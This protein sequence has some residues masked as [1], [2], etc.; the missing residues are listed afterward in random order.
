MFIREALI[1][2]KKDLGRTLD[3]LET[4]KDIGAIGYLGISTGAEFAPVLLAGEERVKAA[5]LLSGAMPV[6]MKLM[7]ESNPVN[8]TP[9]MKTPVLMLNGRYDS[10]LLPDA[11]EWMFRS[12][13]TAMP[14]KAH[15]LVNSGHSVLAPEVRNQ[16]I[17]QILDWF[18]RHL[19]SR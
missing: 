2:W 6:Q 18:D 19:S 9:R 8:F 14:N 1:A 10:I 16:T 17:H 11:Q 4:R 5:V 12:L 7:P 3:Y 13:G 15:V